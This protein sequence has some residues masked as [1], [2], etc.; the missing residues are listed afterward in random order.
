MGSYRARGGGRDAAVATRRREESGGDNN[1]RRGHGAGSGVA[2]GEGASSSPVVGFVDGQW[3]SGGI[4]GD[5]ADSD[6][7]KDADPGGKQG[8]ADGRQR[9]SGHGNSSSVG[10][11]AVAETAAKATVQGTSGDVPR[12]PR[13]DKAAPTATGGLSAAVAKASGRAVAGKK[14][15]VW[16]AA[17]G[18]GGAAKRPPWGVTT[19]A[20]VA[21]PMGGGNGSGLSPGQAQVGC[22]FVR[23]PRFPWYSDG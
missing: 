18:G 8:N 20:G 21:A 9:E 16:G 10:K 14:K 11:P 6:A 22:G 23:G 19:E 2:H 5:D 15:L 12:R 17:G 7:S 4:L 13:W 1:A 3:V